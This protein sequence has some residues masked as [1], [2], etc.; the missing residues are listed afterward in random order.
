MNIQTPKHTIEN[1]QENVM[2]LNGEPC[3]RCFNV[4]FRN[5]FIINNIKFRFAT[6]RH[7]QNYS[8]NEICVEQINS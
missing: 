2:M 6:T 7:L 5:M 3:A 1:E 8:V 4:R